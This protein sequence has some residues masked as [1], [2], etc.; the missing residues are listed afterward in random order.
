M[1]SLFFLISSCL[2]F[3]EIVYVFSWSHSMTL[4][5]LLPL[6]TILFNLLSSEKISH[7]FN[8]WIIY[9]KS[10]KNC[11]VLCN[12]ITSVNN[13]QIHFSI[14]NCPVKVHCFI[15]FCQQGFPVGWPITIHKYHS[16]QQNQS[17]QFMFSINSFSFPQSQD[18]KIIF[19]YFLSSSL[20]FNLS[21]PSTS[22]CANF[23]CL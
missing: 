14:C 1:F 15:S 22:L 11:K 7:S 19:D 21:S 3:Q 18:P 17:S 5:F 23:K 9:C 6:I 12:T 2:C 4:F 10:T 8:Y 20:T 13:V 16:Y